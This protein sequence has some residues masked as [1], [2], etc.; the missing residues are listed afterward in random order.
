MA[1]IEIKG[2]DRLMSKLRRLPKIM[3]DSAS[4]ADYDIMQKAEGYAVQE[5][6]SSV[7]HGNGELARSLKTEVI[8]KDGK[9]VGR[10]WSDN[11]IAVFRELGTGIHGQESEKDLPLGQSI[12]Y[13][14]TPWFIPVDEVEGDL[15]AL[16]GIPKMK[17]GDKEYYRTNGQPARQ[18]M[19]PAIEKVKDESE[20]IIK[21]RVQQDL[22][23]KLGGGS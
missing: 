10:L 14:Q 17:F 11:Q 18:F 16:Y 9:L 12:T 1:E 6:Q 4:N 13:R 21:N 3:H 19:V 7:K 20:T 2:L 5:L 15:T 22:H 23:E 8:D